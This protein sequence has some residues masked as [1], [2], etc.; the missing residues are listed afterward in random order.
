MDQRSICLFLAMKQLLT[1]AISNE[2]GAV[3]AS[4]AI[5]CSTV[6]NY[7]VNDPRPKNHGYHCMESIGISID[8]GTS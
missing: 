2:L 3:L 5:G 8:R 6:I 4:D 1:Q 7:L